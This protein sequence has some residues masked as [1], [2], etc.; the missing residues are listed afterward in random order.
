MQPEL[1][2]KVIP[3]W[4]MEKYGIKSHHWKINID[5]R[6]RDKLTF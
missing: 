2:D 3:P 6:Y 4:Y 1:T 5:G